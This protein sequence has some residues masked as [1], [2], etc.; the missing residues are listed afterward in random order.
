MRVTLPDMGVRGKPS[1]SLSQTNTIASSDKRV[2]PLP[3]S[4]GC[5][6]A[7]I[8]S[9]PASSR[10]TSFIDEGG[11]LH[12][13]LLKK[14]GRLFWTQGDQPEQRISHMTFHTGVVS[15][16]DDKRYALCSARI[17]SGRGGL[18]TVLSS[19]A[20]LGGIRTSGLP[21]SHHDK[22]S[23]Q[24]LR[25]GNLQKWA[26]EKYSYRTCFVH[27]SCV[28]VELKPSKLDVVIFKSYEGCVLRQMSTKYL[29][30]MLTFELDATA[31][32]YKT[33]LALRRRQYLL[34]FIERQHGSRKYGSVP[35]GQPS[36]KVTVGVDIDPRQYSLHAHRGAKAVPPPAGTFLVESEKKGGAAKVKDV[37]TSVEGVLA[38]VEVLRYYAI[39]VVMPYG[40]G[41]KQTS[42][43]SP[44]QSCDR[45]R[46]LLQWMAR[47]QNFPPKKYS[48]AAYCFEKLV[49]Y[50]KTFFCSCLAVRPSLP[51]RRAELSKEI[52][53]CEYKRR[54]NMYTERILQ[55]E[56]A[57]GARKDR[58]GGGGYH[59]EAVE[60]PQSSCQRRRGDMDDDGENS[61]PVKGL[62]AGGGKQRPTTTPG[63][64]PHP[65]RWA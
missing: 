17:S 15:G 25:Q 23:N 43:Y 42:L 24:I 1:S 18:L 32:S 27:P 20:G 21:L 48:F 54:V 37:C 55:K 14:S 46:I 53:F 11:V 57:K 63:L 38:L 28:M 13:V 26:R 61:M 62:G 2:T 65:P 4:K 35:S 29:T 34:H 33:P 10:K 50:M 30:V 12:K 58:S 19:L 7:V 51:Y 64:A 9:L 59:H 39:P 5:D 16:Y 56:E 49:K 8:G 60:K 36:F 6:T 45:F 40:L 22:Q 31:E 47:K 52:P 44:C 41:D 3:H